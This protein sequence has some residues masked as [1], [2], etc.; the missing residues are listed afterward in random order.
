MERCC[1]LVQTTEPPPGTGPEHLQCCGSA[2]PYTAVSAHMQSFRA[3]N[4]DALPLL[5]VGWMQRWPEK[6]ARVGPEGGP[7]WGHERSTGRNKHKP[8]R[9]TFITLLWAKEPMGLRTG[10][11]SNKVNGGKTPMSASFLW[12]LQSNRNKSIHRSWAVRGASLLCAFSSLSAELGEPVLG[13]CWSSW[14][15][16]VFHFHFL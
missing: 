2:H 4:P 7:L 6:T 1:P 9:G 5:Q 12:S 8:A 13:R 15:R 16:K 3:T 14:L 10:S 11:L